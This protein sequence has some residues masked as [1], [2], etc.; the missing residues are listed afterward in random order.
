MPDLSLLFWPAVAF[1]SS[2][3]ILGLASALW[4]A[5]LRQARM[6][7]SVLAGV[8]LRLPDPAMPGAAAVRA[9][10]PRLWSVIETLAGKVDILR[11]EDPEVIALRLTRAGLSG[12]EWR[13]IYAM[14]KVVP[15][16]LGVSGATLWAV[17][18]LTGGADLLAGVFICLGSTL[19]LM[20]ASDMWLTH[21][22]ARRN[23]SIRRVFPGMLELLAVA[24]ESGLAVGP[25]LRKVSVRLQTSC[26]DLA[27]E[28]DRLLSELSL[29]PDREDAYARLAKRIDL[30]EV[31]TFAQVLS[32]TERF[33]TPFSAALR[34]L[35][36]E[37]RAYRLLRIEEK[38]GRLPVLLAVPL[39]ICILPALFVVIAGPGAI[40]MADNLFSG[41]L[42]PENSP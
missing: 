32:Q 41:A 6:T 11:G 13:V 37:L 39:I 1:V 20:R 23:R 29:M 3:G 7:R 28:L 26:P 34:T 33:G 8:A 21:R 2:F 24:C 27:E 38:A 31:A 17:I 35:M 18:A 22:T 16:L 42:T 9:R 14:M 40:T 30:P 10:F 15:L 25:A 12:R 19:M 36:G 5:R 4:M